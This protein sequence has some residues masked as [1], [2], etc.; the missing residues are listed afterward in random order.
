[1]SYVS[2]NLTKTQVKELIESVANRSYGVTA[3]ELS[4]KQLYRCVATVVRDLLLEKRSAF[5]KVYKAR[6]RKRVHYLSMEFLMG[7][8]LKNNL[9]NMELDGLFAET[10]QKYYKVNLDDLYECEP[11]AGLGN[12]GL[13]RLAACYLDCLCQGKLPRNGTF[14][15]F[16]VRIFSNRKFVNGWQT[17]LPDNWLPGGDVW[18]KERP[19]KAQIVRFGG[20][21]QEI[22][23][24][25]G[26]VFKQVNCQ[27]VGGF[28][29]RYG[30][31]RL[32]CQRSGRTSFVVCPQL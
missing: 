10:L 21:V 13:G 24:E 6:E 29:L 8:S 1:M 28:P 16:R 19:D 18:L 12:G 32:P 2:G 30:G 25:N 22:W 3:S 5:N 11:D 4:N 27:E 15:P 23:T 26:P 7:R 14:S 17:E 9:F 31:G 20:E